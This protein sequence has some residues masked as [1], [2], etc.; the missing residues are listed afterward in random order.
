MRW[1]VHTEC[2]CCR[3]AE[4]ADEAD[5]LV[6]D[7]AAPFYDLVRIADEAVWA[8]TTA[9]HRAARQRRKAEMTCD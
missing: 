7:T 9:K 6:I 4:M 2:P 3:C 1:R 5:P 8:E